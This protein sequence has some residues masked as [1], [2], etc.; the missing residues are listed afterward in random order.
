MFFPY[1]FYEKY[2]YH[3]E[4]GLNKSW[5]CFFDSI[6]TRVSNLGQ[7]L[8]SKEAIRLIRGA[9]YARVYT[10]LYVSYFITFF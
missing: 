3:N 4:L 8:S 1:K 9:T 5:F 7:I 10:V 6:Y 2:N